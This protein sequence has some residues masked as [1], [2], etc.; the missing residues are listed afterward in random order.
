MLY[1]RA[2][3]PAETT[4]I[5]DDITTK[6]AVAFSKAKVTRRWK[7]L[8]R[9]KCGTLSSSCDYKLPNGEQINSLCVHYLAYHR[10]EVS[11]SDLA[12]IERIR[13]TRISRTRLLELIK[14]PPRQ[15]LLIPKKRKH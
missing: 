14:T 1:V 5:L 10:S 13:S 3:K 9:C 11:P 6:I 8:Y 12:R 7:G 15:L 2:K 4:P